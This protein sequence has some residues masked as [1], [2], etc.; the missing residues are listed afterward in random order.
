MWDFFGIITDNEVFAYEP[1]EYQFYK[2]FSFIN[3]NLVL[4]TILINTSKC[5]LTKV[6]P[7]QSANGLY[8]YW[9][10]KF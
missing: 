2:K 3:F 10:K 1:T 7:I 8:F 9:K 5:I 4:V 6:R